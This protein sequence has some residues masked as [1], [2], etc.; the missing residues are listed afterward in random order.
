MRLLKLSNKKL[1]ILLLFVLLIPNSSYT[2]EPIDIWDL[3]N[4]KNK[5]K[6]EK[7]NE[8]IEENINKLSNIKKDNSNLVLVEEDEKFISNDLNL[9]GLYD[10]AENDLNLN[11]W[12]LSD[13]EKIIKLVEKIHKIKLS[14]D[15]KNIYK[16]LIL[17][18][19]FP[20]ENNIDLSEFINLKIEWLIENGDL[21]LI[22]DFI[23]KNDKGE[24][25][26]KLAKHYLDKNL[27]LGKIE[28]SCELFSIMKTIPNTEYILKYKIYCLIYAD[29]KEIAQLQYDLLKESGFKDDFFDKLY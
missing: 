24:F 21:N 5:N 16:K 2:N 18:N 19:A 9:V 3:E 17:T 6:I 11:M 14:D 8:L 20:P 10:H 22:K 25:N 27:S 26:S 4:I 23:I 13:G 1:L 29:Q 7:E 28:E 12:E 15:A